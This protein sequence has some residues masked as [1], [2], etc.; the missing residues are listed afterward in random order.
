MDV[1][2]HSWGLLVNAEKVRYITY[3]LMTPGCRRPEVGCTAG[4]Q[5]E[6]VTGNHM[7]NSFQSAKSITQRA[8]KRKGLCLYW[9]LTF[10]YAWGDGQHGHDETQATIDAQKD[11]VQ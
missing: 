1:F 4:T 7:E 5:I 9:F 11:F 3:T 8:L 6:D 10:L 2:L